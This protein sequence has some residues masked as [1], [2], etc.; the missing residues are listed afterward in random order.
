MSQDEALLEAWLHISTSI[1]NSRIV[2]EM[3]YN[4]SRI[5]NVLYQN[6]LSN[7]STPLTAT[8][9]CQKTKILKSQMNRILTQ[10]EA[11]NVITRTRSSKDKRQIYISLNVEQAKDYAK[12]HERILTLIRH[13]TSE[14]GEQDTT[15][16]I[17]TLHRIS[18]IV[19]NI[20]STKGE[21]HD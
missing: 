5:C 2:S 9:L 18:D 12:Q 7:D 3:S 11:R 17:H 8:D 21:N 1:Q 4:E 20:L 15:Q 6:H 19:D 16:T 13:I 14:L 10:L